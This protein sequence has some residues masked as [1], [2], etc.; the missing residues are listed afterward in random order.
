LESLESLIKSVK[1]NRD[2]RLKSVNLIKVEGPTTIRRINIHKYHPSKTLPSSSSNKQQFVERM[3]DIGAS[4]SVSF[5]GV[6]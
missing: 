4:M 2:E 5:G 3:M 6:V 1:K